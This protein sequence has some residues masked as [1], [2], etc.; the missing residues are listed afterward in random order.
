MTEIS[1]RPL[2]LRLIFAGIAL[3]I[4]AALVLAGCS[5]SDAGRDPAARLGAQRAM[6]SEGY[7]LLYA[8]ATKID[9]VE[10]VLYVKTE[11]QDFN[12]VVTAISTYGGELK[13]EL[14]RIAR[15]YPGVR[16]DLEAL[17]EMEVRKRY[18]LG[19]DRLV[20]FAPLASH[21][22]REYERTMLI[23]LSNA[24]N[25]ESYL[26]QV[27]AAEEPDAGLKKFLLQAEKRYAELQRLAA[28][29]LARDHFR[30]EAKS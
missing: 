24:L 18:A 21:S 1:P 10:L 14:E 3:I 16:I 8:D 6:L 29:L 20:Q 11:T 22:P 19:K 27:M 25:H 12:D 13:L 26:C 30:G 15:D 9:R 23:A 17:P 7:S 28:G 2:V 5:R 4:V